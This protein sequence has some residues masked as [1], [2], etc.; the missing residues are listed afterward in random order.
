MNFGMLMVLVWLFLEKN[1][2]MLYIGSR[3]L[4]FDDHQKSLNRSKRR[5]RRCDIFFRDAIC[6]LPGNLPGNILENI[7]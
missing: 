5:Q 7:M 1:E 3:M 6:W 2:E 4:R